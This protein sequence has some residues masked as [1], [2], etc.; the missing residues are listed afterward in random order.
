M[1]IQFAIP[2]YQRSKKLKDK[3]LSFLERVGVP[4]ENITIFLKNSEE[5]NIYK[6]DI[7]G[8]KF[9]V[10]NTSNLVE[11]RNFITKY[12]PLETKII[13]IDD[14]IQGIQFLS[15]DRTFLPTVNRLFEI[16]QEENCTAFGF[17]PTTT[18]NNFYLKERVALGLQYICF[19][20]YG[21]I[22]KGLQIPDCYYI[23]H[24][25]FYSCYM[26]QLEGKTIRYEGAS[27]KT[28][29]FAKGGLTE[30]RAK[31][32]LEKLK[33]QLV[34]EYPSLVRFVL[35][36]NNRPDVVFKRIPRAFKVL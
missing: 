12:Y 25:H 5:E 3:T 11:K 35:K 22:N 1:E 20:C 32:E 36:K 21:F 33:R 4:K 27:I 16:C 29:Y 26:Y 19:A 30:A 34:S 8:Y 17:Y 14:D 23:N 28:Q 10:C 15:P 7:S 24:D 9:V 31:G 18:S 13:G 6:Q 2:S